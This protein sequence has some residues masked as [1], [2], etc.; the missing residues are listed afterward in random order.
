MSKVLFGAS[1]AAER[2]PW[3][4]L[5]VCFARRPCD[6]DPQG[7]ETRGQA[8]LGV[9]KATLDPRCVPHLQVGQLAGRP[10]MQHARRLEASRQCI[11]GM[12]AGDQIMWIP[13]VMQKPR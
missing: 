10:R 2:P 5:I 3:G 8:H 9:A 4:T 1:F 7:I 11:L 12:G 13:R 6:P